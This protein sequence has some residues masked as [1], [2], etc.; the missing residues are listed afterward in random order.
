MMIW[1][2]LLPSGYGDHRSTQLFRPVMDSQAPGKKP[3]PV[4]VVDDVVLMTAGRGQ[5]AGHQL[6]PGV[7]IPAGIS[8][9]GLFARR[10]R[11]GMDAHHLLHGDREEAERD[12]CPAGPIRGEGQAPQVFQGFDIRG[13][14]PEFIELLLVE[15]DGCINPLR[16][17]D[18]AF[19][20]QGLQGLPG[21]G[22]K[23]FIPDHR[24]FL[25]KF[26]CRGGVANPPSVV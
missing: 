2:L 24:K 12:N 26:T 21:Q 19:Q 15:G 8:H 16:R 17:G 5:G 20:L 23:F 10:P 4:G 6:G 1:R 18:E 22:F 13:L 14:D 25:R 7:N 3:V 11:R 9:D